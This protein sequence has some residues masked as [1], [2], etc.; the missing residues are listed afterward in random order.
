MLKLQ[1]S[2][3]SDFQQIILRNWLKCTNGANSL[4]MKYPFSL[5]DLSSTYHIMVS[6]LNTNT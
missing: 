3:F 6:A 1:K 2:R 5:G 4:Q